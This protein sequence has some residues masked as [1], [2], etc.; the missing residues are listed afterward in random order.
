MCTKKYIIPNF[1]LF[2]TSID[3]GVGRPYGVEHHLVAEH[4]LFTEHITKSGVRDILL[5]FSNHRDITKSGSLSI[6]AT[7]PSSVKM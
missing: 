7:D 1:A 5:R 6:S 3:I 2:C 4:G